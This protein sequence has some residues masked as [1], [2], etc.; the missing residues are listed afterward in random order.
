MNIEAVYGVRRNPLQ[1]LWSGTSQNDWRK[2]VGGFRVRERDLTMKDKSSLSP[3][4]QT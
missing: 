1:L 3:S 4:L 2:V